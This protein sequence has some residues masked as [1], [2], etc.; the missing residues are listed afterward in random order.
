[1]NT[2]GS[3]TSYVKLEYEV[4]TVPES[5]AERRWA[6]YTTSDEESGMAAVERGNACDGFSS[7]ERAAAMEVTLN[8]PDGSLDCTKRTTPA[9]P[10]ESVAKVLMRSRASP[11]LRERA[12]L[13][14][15]VECSICDVLLLTS[16]SMEAEYF[17]ASESVTTREVPETT[18]LE[19]TDMSPPVGDTLKGE[20]KLA[21]TE[22]CTLKPRT[23]NAIVYVGAEFRKGG[24]MQVIAAI[25]PADT[26]TSLIFWHVRDEELI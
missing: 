24:S 2:T 4:K 15:E 12:T 9:R 14:G 26:L 18:P 19:V 25:P 23:E 8:V 21:V 16:K 3:P 10:A 11:E 17:E 1:M 13:S 20:T 22:G 7:D 5:V 6:R